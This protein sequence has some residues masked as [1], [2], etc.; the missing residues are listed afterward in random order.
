MK[1]H[2]INTR[3]LFVALRNRYYAAL[4]EMRRQAPHA[5]KVESRGGAI[6]RASGTQRGAGAHQERIDRM[7][8]DYEILR[9][10]S[11][12]DQATSADYLRA[13][14]IFEKWGFDVCELVDSAK[15]EKGDA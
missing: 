1:I 6:D 2:S 8:A 5:E 12:M 3:G 15:A 14:Q 7:T 11:G 4:S 13:A 10:I 9:E